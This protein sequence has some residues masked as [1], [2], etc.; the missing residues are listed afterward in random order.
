MSQ[1]SIEF[2]SSPQVESVQD[3]HDASLPHTGEDIPV[4]KPVVTAD[5]SWGHQ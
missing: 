4:P 3:V 1:S 5:Q 2:E